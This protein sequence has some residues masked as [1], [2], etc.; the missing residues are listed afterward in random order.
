MAVKIQYYH[1]KTDSLELTVYSKIIEQSGSFSCHAR[2]GGQPE[3]ASK[4]DKQILDSRL[5]GNDK[6]WMKKLPDSSININF[7]LLTI[8]KQGN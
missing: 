1:L 7:R 4:T 6:D 5:R 8:L 2:G 3:T